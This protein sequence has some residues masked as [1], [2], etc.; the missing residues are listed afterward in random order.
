MM[1]P[2]SHQRQKQ[3]TPTGAEI[4]GAYT[5]TVRGTRGGVGTGDPASTSSNGRA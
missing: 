5:L 4:N 1:T 3:G 2:R